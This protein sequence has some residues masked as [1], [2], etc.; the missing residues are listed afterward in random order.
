MYDF[1]ERG[2]SSSGLAYTVV[3]FAGLWALSGYRLGRG[4][5]HTKDKSEATSESA[6]AS[7]VG[8]QANEQPAGED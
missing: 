1:F 2:L 7:Q 3:P 8:D 5:Q 4:F 6:S